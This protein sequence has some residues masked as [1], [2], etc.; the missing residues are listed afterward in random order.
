MATV[1][2]K[3]DK[4]S[5]LFE[6][7]TTYEVLE[8][9]IGPELTR[10]FCDLFGGRTMYV[11]A[12]PLEGH[13]VVRALGWEAAEKLCSYYRV[14]SAGARV[15]IPK[16]IDHHHKNTLADVARLMDEGVSAYD[17]AI[18]LN[19]HERT[20]FRVRQR[21]YRQ[22]AKRLGTRIKNLR[23]EGYSVEQIAHEMEMPIL[24]LKNIIAILDGDKERALE[25]RR[26]NRKEL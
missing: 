16:G 18:A 14:R 25:R 8:E 13:W 19:L 23:A 17:T 5:S 12:E 15:K 26:A 22:R 20:I 10:H 21:V 3:D 2:I 24:H 4:E 7:L 9:L 11:P 6:G 1:E